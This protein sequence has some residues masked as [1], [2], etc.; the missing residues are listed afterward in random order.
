MFVAF[1]ALRF[2]T[3]S[4][5]I[6]YFSVLLF[7]V[8]SRKLF[9]L[10]LAPFFCFWLKP[11]ERLAPHRWLLFWVLSSILLILAV[12]PQGLLAVVSTVPLALWYLYKSGKHGW[13]RESAVALLCLVIIGLLT[14]LPAMLRQA[15][16]YVLENGPINQIAY[17]VPWK[18]SWNGIEQDKARW[19]FVSTLEWFRM[20][21]IWVPLAAAA[22]ILYFSNKKEK[23]KY[24][25]RVA[26]PVLIFASLMVPYSM[27]R[28]DPSAPSRPGLISNFAWAILLP[29]LI[30]P[31]IGSRGKSIL[32]LGIAFI[33]SG[34]GIA[35]ISK[36]SLT[37]LAIKNEV[38][39][40]W[41][42]ATHGMPNMGTGA[43]ALPHIDRLIRINGY[44]STQLAPRETY[45]DLTGHNADYLY[46]DRPPAIPITAPYNMASYQQQQRAIEQLALDL[47]EIALLQAENL[48]F[49]GGGM[50]LR[51]HLIY[52]F[53]LNNYNAELHDGYVYGRAK[54]SDQNPLAVSFE[55]KDWSDVNWDRGI[56]RTESAVIIRDPATIQYLKE[57]D[58]VRLPDG[59]TR[60]ITRVWPQ[61]N[62]IWLEGP[63]INSGSLGETR[64]I[65]VLLNDLRKQEVSSQ[66]ME[67]VFVLKNLR[68]LPVAW[69]RSANS[70]KS[71]MKPVAD[72]DFS[73]SLMHDLVRDGESFRVTGPDPYLWIDLAPLNLTGRSAGLLKF[74]FFCPDSPE[75]T[76]QTFWWGDNMTGPGQNESLFFGSTDGSLIVPLDAHPGWVQMK[77]VAGL[78]M[79]L[80]SAGSCQ[81]FS[82]K[83]AS[84][85][86][87]MQ[88][89]DKP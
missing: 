43:V 25:V 70:L 86:Q 56:N 23:Y 29:L 48:D 53:V 67:R 89:Q 13:Q 31:L 50:A 73:N 2:Y 7:G 46:F 72:L 77:K 59:Q 76:M 33:C 66:L 38:N 62:A 60:R 32:V 30:A 39:N 26:L 17:G 64:Q 5:G 49:D 58:V 68:K 75:A 63:R 84:L 61:G 35:S 22:I 45:L 79:D 51:T 18:A 37:D 88:V 80:D 12:P 10:F 81:T 74:D 36:D 71:A 82:I 1:M 87:R 47:P 57:G 8:I 41:S 40:L 3:G 4:I 28:I 34:L 42:G 52:R 85:Q 69:G 6:A 11:Y 9:F 44:L 16:G 54:A 78:R 24:I 27:G 21:W 65:D 55:V 83:K 20:S 19:L 15:I 14:P